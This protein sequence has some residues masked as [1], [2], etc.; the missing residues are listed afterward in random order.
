ML[1]LKP[2]HT[3]PW[4]ICISWEEESAREKVSI[5]QRSLLADLFWLQ[6]VPDFACLYESTGAQTE[7]IVMEM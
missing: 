2:E 3:G 4:D 1:I 7:T 5:G 6:G